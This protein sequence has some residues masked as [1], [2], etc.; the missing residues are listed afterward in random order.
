MMT[1]LV[2]VGDRTIKRRRRRR[3]GVYTL[4]ELIPRPGDSFNMGS[5]FRLREQA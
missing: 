1:M 2:V 5:M 3:K 4:S